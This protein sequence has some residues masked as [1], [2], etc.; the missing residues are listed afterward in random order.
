MYKRYY[1]NKLDE[2]VEPNKVVIIQGPRQV[3]KTTL[4]N[5]Y[6][7]NY[8]KGKYKYEYLTGDS[9]EAKNIFSSS[10]LNTIKN[11]AKGLDLVVIDEAQKIED[12]GTGLKILVD[13]VKNIRI[14][15]TGSASF[16]LVN[17]VG[18]PL[19]GRKWD[20]KL[21]PLAQLE[22][23]KNYNNTFLL[24]QDLEKFL[25][26]GSYP[27]VLEIDNTKQ[28]I[29]Y[30]QNFVDSFL[31]KD[32]LEFSGVKGSK[33]II[34][35]LKLLAFQV[36]S[37]VSLTELANSLGVNKLT[38]AKYLDLFEKTYII[39]NLRGYSRNLRKEI[40]TT[41]K[42]YFYDNGILNALTGNF[43]KINVR[44]DIGALWENFLVM[45]GLKKQEYK[46]IHSNNYFWRTWD[47]DE[48]DF[49]EERDGRLYGFE[50]KW[51]NAKSKGIHKFTN[52]YK[53]AEVEI[54]NRENYIDFVI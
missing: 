45:E 30:L 18:E 16:D 6:L 13:H 40:T 22:L 50:F 20:L 51:G 31:L 48:V 2:Y 25:I 5:Q 36:G 54:I 41:G 7:K 29:E 1:D 34:D 15:V 46:K 39:Y 24:K 23:Q 53:E 33:F 9:I 8:C 10:S 37:L 17:K 4:V 44:N 28:K 14:I 47:K 49:V 43:N 3:G 38:V 35:L 26:Y 11:F 12:I 21:F 42:Y 32:V 27:E 52:E 19:V